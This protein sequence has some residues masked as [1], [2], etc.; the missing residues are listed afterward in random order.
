[1]LL[2][3]LMLAAAVSLQAVPPTPADE[4]QFAASDPFA[5][6]PSSFRA[7]VAMTAGERTLRLEVYRRGGDRA[8]VRFLDPVER[9][10]F[11]LR[12][13]R[14]VWFLAPGSR[15][16]LRVGPGHRLAGA[17][18]DELVGLRLST[19]Y[20]IASVEHSEGLVTFVLEAR[21]ADIAFARARHVVRR[22]LGLPLR[23]E[24]QAADGR[25]LRVLEYSAWRNEAELVPERVVVND[26]VRHGPAVEVRFLSV[27]AEELPDGLFDPNDPSERDRRFAAR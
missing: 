9:G 1:L 11:L 13:G 22:D 23:T 8:L 16:P 10:K 19:S 6:A 26:L 7:E 20:A 27:E 24:L 25:V 4:R 17:S 2:V 14:Q 5:R 12:T 21:D 15:R 3:A 18:L